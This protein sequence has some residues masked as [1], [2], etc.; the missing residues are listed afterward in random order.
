MDFA[1]KNFRGTLISILDIDKMRSR[2]QQLQEL[3]NRYDNWDD[4]DENDIRI[5]SSTNNN[6]GANP[7]H[8]KLNHDFSCSYSF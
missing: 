5:G 8:H 4:D 3:L 2:I 1:C 7:F 6:K